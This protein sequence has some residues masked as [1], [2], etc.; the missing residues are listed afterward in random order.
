M[1]NEILRQKFLKKII[2]KVITSK[3]DF[4]KLQTTMLIISKVEKYLIRKVNT[5][6]RLL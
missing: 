3:S 4:D 2:K 1:D 5:Q 6:L